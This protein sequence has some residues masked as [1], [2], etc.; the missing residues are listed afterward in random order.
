MYS[1]KLENL[2]RHALADGI[3]TEKEK[4]ILVKN[5]EAEG[6]D[7]DEFEVVLEARLLRKQQRLQPAEKPDESK[8]NFIS[9]IPLVWKIALCIGIGIVC[10]FLVKMFIKVIIYILILAILA[11]GVITFLKANKINK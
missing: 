2:I 4:Q 5:A 1:E 6:I 10:F 11:V 9:S 3:L 7:P 8:W